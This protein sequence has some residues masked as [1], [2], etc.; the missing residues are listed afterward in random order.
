MLF[1]K[2]KRRQTYQQAQTHYHSKR[3][4]WRLLQF[5]KPI[6]INKKIMGLSFWMTNFG[7]DRRR[8]TKRRCSQ[9]VCEWGKSCQCQSVQTEWCADVL[10]AERCSAEWLTLELMSQMPADQQLSHTHLQPQWHMSQTSLSCS[11]I[12]RQ[13]K[14]SLYTTSAWSPQC[15]NPDL[16][17]RG[18]FPFTSVL[19][20]RFSH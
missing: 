15:L 17:L 2:R 8:L 7:C 4:L 12:V 13:K 1:Y 14:Q 20:F 10:T 18:C 3:V 5:E 6:L 11:I 19:S 9:L 16:T